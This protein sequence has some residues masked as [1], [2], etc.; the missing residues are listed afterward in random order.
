MAEV[1]DQVEDLNT[2]E[3]EYRENMP[4]GLWG[5]DRYSASEDASQNMEDAMNE[6][7]DVDSE[8]QNVIDS[9]LEAVG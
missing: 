8:V 6:L 5:S 3:E 2:E 9:I 7:D 4:E 1:K